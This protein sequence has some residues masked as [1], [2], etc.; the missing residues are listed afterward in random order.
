MPDGSACDAREQHQ[1]GP[2]G[3]RR[4]DHFHDSRH[5]WNDLDAA[6]RNSLL[7]RREDSGGSCDQST[8]PTSASDSVC[9]DVAAWRI[10]SLPAGR[11]D[12]PPYAQLAR[13][14]NPPLFGK[15]RGS[16]ADGKGIGGQQSV[17]EYRRSMAGHT[18][19]VRC[20][21]CKRRFYAS[22]DQCPE[23]GHKS[24]RGWLKTSVIALCILLAIIAGAMF[25]IFLMNQTI[26]QERLPEP[27]GTN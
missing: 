21:R 23:C 13:R 25:A 26:K 6:F 24:T 14:G 4:D 22:E 12:L 20:K 9:R 27:S 2:L 15:V 5:R 11:C 3:M 16:C 1:I 17:S 18:R 8:S 7:Q 19:V 10:G